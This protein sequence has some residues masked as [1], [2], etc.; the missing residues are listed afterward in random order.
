MSITAQEAADTVLA[1][2]RLAFEKAL[3]PIMDEIRLA[4]ADL[5]TE[6]II[7]QTVHSEVRERL[8]SLGYK[9]SDHGSAIRV[10]FTHLM[11]PDWPQVALL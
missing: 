1:T 3:L 4:I 6:V 5:R 2:K 8:H 10:S 9:T 11:P 7:T